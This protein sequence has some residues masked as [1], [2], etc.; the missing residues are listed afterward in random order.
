MGPAKY[1]GQ[2]VALASGARKTLSFC[3]V[4]DIYQIKVPVYSRF[5][6]ENNS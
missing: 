4:S 2:M 6:L 1:R 5:T 3:Q